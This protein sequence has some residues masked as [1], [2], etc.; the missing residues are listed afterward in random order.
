MNTFENLKLTKQLQLAIKELGFTQPTPIQIQSFPVILSG[1]D[2][3]GV[4]QTGT[5]KTLAYL[6]PL[7][8]EYT[9]RKSNNPRIVIL[10]PTRELVVQVVEMIH[11]LC[12][13]ITIRVIGVYGGTNINTQK[14]AVSKG[15]D[16]IVG[17]PG[18][19]YDLA[20]TR[21]LQLSEVKKLV[22]DE[23]D[24]MLD[25]GFRYQLSNI[26]DLI[27]TKRQSIMFSASMT[28][29]VDELIED[30]FISPSKITIAIS[31]TRLENIDQKCYSVPNFYTKCNLLKHLLNN[32]EEFNKVLVFVSS[33]KFADRLFETLEDDFGPETGVIHSN[34]SQ[35]Y[36]LET[37]RE[38]EEGIT[39]ILIATDIVARGL[40]FD[41][42]SHVIN[43]DTPSYPE[44]YMHR[45]GR[46]GRAEQAGK[47]I[48]F[49]TEKE[50]LAK[51]AI[52]KLMNYKI[53]EVGIPKTVEISKRLTIEERPDLTTGSSFDIGKKRAQ[54]EESAFHEKLEK[55]KKVNLGS[56]Y[57]REPKVFKKRLTKGDKIGNRIHAKRK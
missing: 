12:K 19:L 55:N 50:I 39:R 9:F 48:L 17:T 54:K 56:K 24:V 8:N 27:P 36:R 3:V 11:E 31:G 33:K 45:I 32:R 40:D 53:P 57:R 29:E 46:S 2:I 14:E 26:F 21:V 43:F 23:V 22:I 37:I 1:K 10:V 42:V 51:E 15:V 20:L 49:Y 47:T 34:K 38:F 44:N 52:E 6:L 18:R 13:Y 16:I 4:A 7:L 35:N 25:G 5:G 28:D 30:F 41:N